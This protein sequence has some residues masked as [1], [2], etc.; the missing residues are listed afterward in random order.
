MN[1]ST[2]ETK[3]RQE[4]IEVSAEHGISYNSALETLH[5][6]HVLIVNT[7]VEKITNLRKDIERMIY[8][9]FG[10]EPDNPHFDDLSSRFRT[11]LKEFKKLDEEAYNVYIETH[12][13]Y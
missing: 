3:Y 11:L 13:I 5:Q 1:Q 10:Q 8:W 12:D 7:L 9:N 4:I 6:D 2:F